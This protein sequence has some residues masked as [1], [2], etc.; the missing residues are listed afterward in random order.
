MFHEYMKTLTS[1]SVGFA[2]LPVW[3]G[4]F[5]NLTFDSPRLDRVRTDETL[6]KYGP[7]GDLLVGWEVSLRSALEDWQPYTGEIEL[8][9][10]AIY[11][12][13][14][15]NSEV[16]LGGYG[17]WIN[18]QHP[19]IGGMPIGGGPPLPPT[20]IRLTT[21]GTVPAEAISFE[22][23]EGA[24]TRVSITDGLSLAE[25]AG[26]LRSLDVRQF[27]GKEVT[28]SVVGIQGFDVIGFK[29]IPEPQTWALLGTG[30]GA[31]YWICRKR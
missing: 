2:I 8:D 21:T 5:V 24:G 6:A 23:F 26:A 18:E 27:A 20:E 16:G 25:A 10:I 12:P 15:L 14:A 30:L 13:V 19:P 28:I 9:R 1:I 11:T 22:W 17:V 4:E 29:A 3:G 7:V 31:A